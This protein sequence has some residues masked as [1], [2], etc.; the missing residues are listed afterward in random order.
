MNFLDQWNRLHNQPMKEPKDIP[1]NNAYIYSAYFF[2]IHSKQKYEGYLPSSIPFGRHP[3]PNVSQSYVNGVEIVPNGPNMSHDEIMGVC[4]LSQDKA[5]RIC[6]YLKHSYNQFCESPAFVPKKWTKLNLFSTIRRLNQLRKEANPRTATK[7]YPD[8]W[9]ITF[10]QKPEFMWVY[11]R[12]AGITPSLFERFWVVIASLF[13]L[14]FWKKNDPDLLLAFSQLH[15][16]NNR[17]PVGVE[18]KLINYLVWSKIHKL[19]GTI[20][21]MLLFKQKDLKFKYYYK[22]PWITGK[23]C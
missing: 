6:H 19:Y 10:W 18:G 2:A 17:M 13:A 16:Q 4:M 20:P 22:H 23:L 12:C 3:V 15:L 14:A 5:I 1:C 21:N 9:C 7:N 11:K 8:L